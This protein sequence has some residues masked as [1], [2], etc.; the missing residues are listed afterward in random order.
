VPLDSVKR[1][2]GNLNDREK[3][4]VTLMGAVFAAMLAFLVVFG[5]TTA[6]LDVQ[7]ENEKLR[8]LLA[9]MRRGGKKL[10]EQEADRLRIQ[11][12]YNTKAPAL[13]SFLESQ[14]RTAGLTLQ[15][16]T[17]QP[18]KAADGF[19]RRS[20]NIATS[21]GM[22][23]VIDLMHS[24]DTSPYPVG[25]SAI[26]IRR[27]GGPG[28]NFTVKIGVQAFD[29]EASAGAQAATKN[30]RAQPAGVAGPPPPP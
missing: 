9:E 8:N 12:R 28:D 2:W 27:N 25:V 18:E 23:P 4:L 20:A 26:D 15:S 16:V 13:G 21:G 6:I 19:R 1:A 29:R 22:R 7:E 30:T 24:I 5:S 14:A 17:D 10:R 3:R 11:Q